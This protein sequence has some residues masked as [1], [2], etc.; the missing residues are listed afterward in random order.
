MNYLL[1][2]LCICMSLLFVA[3]AF[4]ADEQIIGLGDASGGFAFSDSNGAILNI[5]IMAWGP[6]W[7]WT[8]VSS[9]VVNEDGVN[10]SVA[11]FKLNNVPVKLTITAK[12]TADNKLAVTAEIVAERDTKC[13]MVALGITPGERYNGAK[14]CT[15]INATGKSQID[16]PFGKGSLGNNV[17][18]LKF[19]KDKEKTV[20]ITFK[21]PVNIPT[22]GAARV[23]VISDDVKAADEHKIEFTIDI[24]RDFKWCATVNEVPFPADWNSWFPWTPTEDYAADSAIG[25]QSWQDMPAGKYGR[26]RMVD[27]KLMLNNKPAKF[28]GVNQCYNNGCAPDKATADKRAALY[29]K[30]GV[31]SVRLHKYACGPGWEGIQSSNSCTTFDKAGLDRMDYFVAALKKQGVYVKLS[32]VFM[33]K[34]GFDDS[35][36]LPY[37]KEFGFIDDTPGARVTCPHGSIF[38]ST[39][40]QDLLIKQTTG[41]MKHKNPY[42]GLTYAEDPGVLVIEL[43]NEDSALFFGTNSVLQKI[44]T[45]RKRASEDFTDW[46][47][48]K[49]GTEEALKK[50]WGDGA[51]N[52]FGNEGFTNESVEARNIVPVGNPWFYDPDQLEGSQ[53]PKKVRL[54]DTMLFMYE[55]QN[56]FYKRY[57]DALRAAGYDGEILSSNWI[58]GRAFSHYY[59]LHSDSLV[60]MIDR[61]NYYGDTGS[62]LQKAGSF[63]LSSGLQ[64]VSNRPF[65]LSE[66]AETFPNEW[67]VEAPAIIGAYGMG[68]QDWDVSYY[69]QNSDEGAFSKIIG[70]QQWDA[71]SP[72]VLGA[73]PAIARQVRRIDVKPASV[74]APR[75][76]NIPSLF[77][78]K[79]GF[80]DQNSAV[81]DF[82]TMDS[83]TVP[84]KALAVARCTIEFTKDFQKTPQFDMK[85]YIKDGA[86]ESSTG[87]LNWY[88]GKSKFSGY[89]TINSSA[90]KAVVGFADGKTAKLDDVTI[91]SK[92][93]FSAIYLTAI[94]PTEDIKTGKRLLITAVARARNTDM[95]YNE[96]SL[97]VR[98]KSP[99][100][101]EP[102][103]AEITLKKA[104]EFTVYVCD[105]AGKR[106]EKTISVKDGK[107]TIDSADSKTLY[108]EVVTK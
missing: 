101:M 106:T 31:N 93:R 43:F 96:G 42:T 33:V 76:V 83:T 68:L 69:F 98:G 3:P 16:L 2:S 34:P 39:E 80:D 46:L 102:V 86:I 26:V 4:S 70:R 103:K 87:E 67:G 38:L 71:T 11:N 17:T 49:Y 77:E 1:I 45:L 14:S 61:H 95:K 89:F 21:N 84:A 12:K 82:K 35:E 18:A 72:Q 53:K 28:W 15:I 40:I 5:D 92:N 57:V 55:K 85:K 54:H 66:W 27:D 23:T 104:S 19:E 108:Y 65:M 20:D 44:P 107:F 99:I 78:G 50:A 37:I 74:T 7:A 64:Q 60:G 59:N 62:M 6:K 58:A 22:D 63:L 100:L 30:Y 90:T 51:L 75:Y 10:S 36:D 13:T 79:L 8:G 41:L 47:M 29:A 24:S 25:M 81:G 91:T 73:F 9:K 52:S 56:Q 105:Q 32:P 97:L 94:E 48:K 88:E